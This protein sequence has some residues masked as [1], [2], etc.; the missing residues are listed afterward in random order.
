LPICSK[1]K[2]AYLDGEYHDCSEPA[3]VG[4]PLSATST[5]AGAFSGAICGSF[6]LFLSCIVFE[7]TYYCWLFGLC[8]GV[9]LGAAVGAVVGGRW[10]RRGSEPRTDVSKSP[11]RRS[12]LLLAVAVIAAGMGGATWLQ[13]MRQFPW[14]L[15]IALVFPAMVLVTMAGGGPHAI[16]GEAWVGPAIFI[17]AVVMWCVVIEAGRRWWECRHQ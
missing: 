12:T 9:P 3:R 1:C 2:V 15:F 7:L 16:S 11:L 13:D 8:L 10:G 14:H 17:V 6:L 5:L 4:E